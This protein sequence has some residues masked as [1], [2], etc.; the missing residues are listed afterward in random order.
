[1]VDEL[2]T[3]EV[4]AQYKL[5]DLRRILKDWKIKAKGYQKIVYTIL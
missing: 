5:D 3:R 1:M 2:Y 4:D